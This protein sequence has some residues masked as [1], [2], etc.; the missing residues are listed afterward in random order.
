[1]IL[2]HSEAFRL[3]VFLTVLLFVAALSCQAQ[4]SVTYSGGQ[5]RVGTMPPTGYGLSNG[6]WGVSLPTMGPNMAPSASGTITA[7][8][9]WNYAAGNPPAYVYVREKCLA[10]AQS[11]SPGTL[12]QANNS[13]GSPTL[14]STVT[15]S[16]AT[17]TTVSCDGTRVSRIDTGGGGTFTLTASPSV[18]GTFS[19]NIA[20]SAAITTKLVTIDSSID[21]SFHGGA[22][23]IPES[24]MSNVATPRFGDTWVDPL[25]YV[26]TAERGLIYKAPRTFTAAPIGSWMRPSRSWTTSQAELNSFSDDAWYTFNS[27]TPVFEFTEAQL[28]EMGRSGPTTIPV[29]LT[30]TDHGSGVEGQSEKAV[31][32]VIF[33]NQYERWRTVS[34]L[35]SNTTSTTLEVSNPG[36]AMAGGGIS[37]T[38]YE[39]PSFWTQMSGSV[40]DLH[41]I[42]SPF[43]SDPRWAAAFELA[44]I[45]AGNI[46]PRPNS[47][48]AN[49]DNCWA[50]QFSTITEGSWSDPRAFFKMTPRIRITYS[51][52]LQNCD[53]Y[54][55][56]GYVGVAANIV[57]KYDSY[58]WAGDFVRYVP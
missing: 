38:W 34:I 21:E 24:D 10:Q 3:R 47:G 30:L 44:N 41:D 27:I 13:L 53:Q 58:Q 22:N 15:V 35:A 51:T 28:T 48:I 14:T 16:G 42:L 31:Y 50:S 26:L 39:T 7:T 54:G 4:W 8:F 6:S 2:S 33:H 20:Y 19:I 1:M 46:L 9:Q 37:C 56:H 25:S 49:F 57:A 11:A 36:Y 32:N 52:L 45:A 12:P 18:S 43:I 17:R 5:A 29:E 23:G 40:D 55:P